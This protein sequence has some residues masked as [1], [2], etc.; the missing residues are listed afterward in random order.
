MNNFKYLLSAAGGAV[1]AYF[2]L[3]GLAYTVVGVAVLFDIVTGIL[4]S[5]VDGSGLSSRKAYR[6]VLKKSGLLMTLGF[7]TFLDVF[8]PFAAK[9]VS[10]TVPE[11]LLF[12]SVICVYIT[13]TECISIIENIYRINGRILPEWLMRFFKTAKE[14]L[15]SKN[16]GESEEK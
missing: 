8:I 5:L 11:N 15:D 12:S 10:L 16:E 6:G 7:G 2:R 4:A 3:Y 1:L 9:S 14:E 13:V